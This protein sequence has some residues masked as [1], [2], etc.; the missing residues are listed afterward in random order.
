[1][2]TTITTDMVKALRQATGAAVLECR[3]A[4]VET[5]GDLE[6]AAALLRERGIAAAE[7]RAGRETRSGM[8][9]LYSHGGGRVGVM[10]EVN[11]ETDFVART[12]EF[13]DFAHEIALQIAGAE[14][15]FVDVEG[16]P[17]EAVEE[18]RETA[19]KAALDEGKSA[20]MVDKIV[21]GRLG[22]YYDEVCLLRQPYLRDE[23]KT[24]SELL[25]E[26]IA[27]TGENITIRRFVR[28]T[29]GEA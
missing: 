18:Q 3:K 1:M 21:E 26:T 7:K 9:E 28:W 17:A 24:V 25:K 8:L 22:K 14:P 6:K 29:V 27:A 19:R 11:C 5:G 2:A 10:V 4:L 12:K 20:G 15:R 23:S 16:V 13:R